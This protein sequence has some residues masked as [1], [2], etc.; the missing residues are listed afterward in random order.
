[1]KLLSNI[2]TMI[3]L[4]VMAVGMQWIFNL[5]DKLKFNYHSEKEY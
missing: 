4:V 3:V 5:K 1:M 2:L